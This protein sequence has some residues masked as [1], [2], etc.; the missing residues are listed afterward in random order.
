[1]CSSDLIFCVELAAVVV[2]DRPDRSDWYAAD[3]EWNQQA[4]FACG[5]DRQQAGVAALEVSEQQGTILI[6]YVSAGAEVARG[7]T[8]D[9]ATPHASASWPIE[10]CAGNVRPFAIPR[11]QAKASGVT[12]GNVKEIGRASC[13]ERV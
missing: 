13:R 6:K 8:S 1:V 4:F 12:L 9:V 2:H 10:S 11:Q 7:S 3:V 5:N